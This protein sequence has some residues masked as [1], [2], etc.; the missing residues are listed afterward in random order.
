MKEKLIYVVLRGKNAGIELTPHRYDDG[1]F[2]AYK[3]NS[4]NDPE[5][6]TTMTESELIT[7]VRAGYHVRMSNRE[8]GHSTSTVKPNIVVMK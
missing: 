5:G 7:L 4:R 2:K 8:F 1:T 6:K 3:T